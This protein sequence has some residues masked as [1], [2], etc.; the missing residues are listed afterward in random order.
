MPLA[1]NRPLLAFA[2]LLIGAATLPSQQPGIQPGGSQRIPQFEN[3]EVSV[4][5]TTVM[6]NA[7]LQMHTHDHPRVLVALQG[8]T[9]K[10]AYADGGSET[11]HWESGKAYWLGLE[12]GKRRHADVNLG[13][14]PIEVMVIELKNAK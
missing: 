13:D 3:S 10:I 5:K 14:K 6:P 12:E 8:G 9:V 11:Q 4:W 1:H 2:A 7:P